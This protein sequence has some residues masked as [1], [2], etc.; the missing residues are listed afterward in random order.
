M[1]LDT[2]IP[3]A[4]FNRFKAFG[5]VMRQRPGNKI[6]NKWIAILITLF[7]VALFLP[8]TQ[9]IQS[10]GQVSTLNPQQRPQQ[11]NSIIAGRIAQWHVK[12]GDLVNKGD[13]L[14]R[15]T[16]IKEDYLDPS[17]LTRVDEQI[18]AKG[19]SIQFYQDKAEATG[20]QSAALGNSRKLKLSQLVNKIKQYALLVG[21]DSISFAAAENQ[22]KIADMQLRRQ[23]Q[24]YDAGLKSL[25]EFEQR[26]QAY[27]DAVSKKISAENKF[28]N[29]RNELLNIKIEQ[30]AI[31]QE[32]T[33][34]ILKATGDRFSTLSEIASTRSE[35]AKLQNQLANYRMRRDFYVITAPQ[36]GQVIKTSKAG[37]G[38]TV[39]EGD[40][41][42]EIVPTVFDV[43][44][45]IFVEPVD[46]PL[47]NKGQKV[48]LQ[49]DGF[50]AI[51]F[52]GWPSSSYGTFGGR[53][54][55]VDPSISIG[56]KFRAWVVP[57]E[58]EKS[59]PEQLRYGSGAKGIALLKDVT[60]IYELWRKLNG[61][62]PEFYQAVNTAGDNKK[63]KNKDEK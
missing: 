45:E 6:S 21:S 33:E 44:V 17:Q 62:P 56:G 19:A 3:Y 26:Q 46:L 49:F 60:I 10:G 42:L 40:P 35:V 11:I 52:S 27:Q 36:S 38:E 47:L 20:S 63:D 23:K 53:I 48:R 61:F 2:K 1:F 5:R 37:I 50:P 7:V 57:D 16:E 15:I 8:W 22:L 39:K 30:S 32:Y 9:N 24:L 29:S 54:A 18:K 41:L 28:Y 55:A 4:Q 43:A 59:W 14:A 12:D 25:V 51:V 34:K 31:G 13:T 58:S